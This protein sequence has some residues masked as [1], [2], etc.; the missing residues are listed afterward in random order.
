MSI[1]MSSSR[2]RTFASLV[3]VAGAALT[4]ALAPCQINPGPVR[5][6]PDLNARS[7]T[8]D[9]VS[10]RQT[11]TPGHPNFGPTP[12]GFH[13][14]NLPLMV[15]ILMANLPASGETYYTS[16]R[17]KGAPDWVNTDQ[18][19]IE[20]KISD[21]DMDAWQKPDQ[22]K[23]MLQAMLEAFLVERCKL[24]VH[25]ETKESA[26]FEME[27][28]KGGPKLKEATPDAPHP[29]GISLPAGGTLVPGG[30]GRTL[31]FYGATMASL[32]QVLSNFSGHPVKDKTGLTGKYDF[33]LERADADVP[34]GGMAPGDPG[35][36]AY[37]VDALGLHLERSRSVV[38]TLVIDHIERP[39]EN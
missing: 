14:S 4:P 26:V 1:Q 3:V 23:V 31:N 21:A 19:T 30:G 22:Q 16:D 20:A 33:V 12:D 8:F 35:P 15:P 18:Y 7:Y 13:S 38:D 37:A 39:S 5:F 36:P 28:G 25:R 27:V 11:K 6:P 2:N 24:A 29:A 34:T 9:V 10:I 17:I 32:A